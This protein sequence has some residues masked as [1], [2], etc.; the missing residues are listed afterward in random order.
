MKRERKPQTGA[1]NVLV[2]P[3]STPRVMNFKAD[4]RKL[5]KMYRSS[6][7]QLICPDEYNS[8]MNNSSNRHIQTISV[9]KDNALPDRQDYNT[10]YSS[11]F[12]D[13]S[14]VKDGGRQPPN[15]DFEMTYN[16]TYTDP[17][18]VIDLNAQNK[19]GFLLRPLSSSSTA[20]KCPTHAL[21]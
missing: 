6:T 19:P 1:S 18:R 5:T 8:P 7:H 12:K 20:L 21:L 14:L 17:S 10:I 13:P 9:W 16:L 11:T 4:V 15:S 3:N 2:A